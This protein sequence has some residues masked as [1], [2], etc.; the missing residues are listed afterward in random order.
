MLLRQ[1]SFRALAEPRRFREADGTIHET[2]LRVRFGEVEERGIALTP[3]GRERYDQATAELAAC[4]AQDA[5]ATWRAHFPPAEI[6][7]AA[8]DLAYFTFRV[9][10]R[11]RDGTSPPPD[12]PA[13][14]ERG[15]LAV[16][17]IVYEDFLPRSAAGMFQSNLSGEGRQD[18]TEAAAELDPGWM[19]EV[20]GRELHDPYALYG[21]Q[22]DASLLR[23]RTALGAPSTAVVA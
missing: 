21:E 17:P 16:D 22:H 3:S 19:A 1:T 4:R 6:D 10:D 2:A 7:F 13:L 9:R 11:R 23:A 20:L 14:L 15:W 8:E 18:R 12:L 5:A